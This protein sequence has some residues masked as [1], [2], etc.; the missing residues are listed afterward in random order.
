MRWFTLRSTVCLNEKQRG[1]N[2]PIRFRWFR[3]SQTT[4]LILILFKCSLL[5]WKAV[6]S[7]GELL[8]GIYA[9]EAIKE[10]WRKE[11]RWRKKYLKRFVSTFE[12]Q[13]EEICR[14]TRW[15]AGNQGVTDYFGFTYGLCLGILT[16]VILS[17]IRAF[18]HPLRRCDSRDRCEL[19]GTLLNVLEARKFDGV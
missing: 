8:R 3:S 13:P 4:F 18:C 1:G 9:N 11:F 15:K 19:I 16:R 14:N 7:K 17:K 2:A 5:L 6:Q 12:K 10:Q